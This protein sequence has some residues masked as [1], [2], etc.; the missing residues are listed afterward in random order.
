GGAS[1]AGVVGVRVFEVAG[2]LLLGNVDQRAEGFACGGAEVG[3][4]VHGDDRLVLP[5]P[6]GRSAA[7]GHPQAACL[8]GAEVAAARLVFELGVGEPEPGEGLAGGVVEFGFG[9]LGHHVVRGP[10]LPRPGGGLVV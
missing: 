10:V 1:S 6:G 7:D 2:G 8:G 5:R 3:G 9:Q 4:G